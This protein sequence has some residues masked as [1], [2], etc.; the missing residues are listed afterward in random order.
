MKI[1]IACPHCNEPLTDLF[2]AKGCLIGFGE[3][4]FE[5]ECLKCEKR[6]SMAVSVSQSAAEVDTCSCRPN[7]FNCPKCQNWTCG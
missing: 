4:L 6:F 1:K 3:S 2:S 5:M 7:E